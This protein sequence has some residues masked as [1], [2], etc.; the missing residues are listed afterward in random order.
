VVFG[1]LVTQFLQPFGK[2]RETSLHILHTIICIGNTDTGI[3]PGFVDIKT[4]AV[5]LDDF[6]RQQ[7]SLLILIVVRQTGTGHPAK[8]SRLWKR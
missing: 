7:I 5:F 3:D 1:K 4:T 8:S 6:E 2:G